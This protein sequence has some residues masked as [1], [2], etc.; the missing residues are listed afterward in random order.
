MA[1]SVT[2]KKPQDELQGEVR[3]DVLGGV[4]EEKDS[5]FQF[6]SGQDLVDRIPD[7][8]SPEWSDYVMRQFADGELV[9]GCPNVAGLRRVTRKL[10]GPI[11][12][13]RGFTIQAP[14]LTDQGWQPAVCDYE[15]VV[16][17]TR[18][19][20]LHG[21]EVVYRDCA[22]TWAGNCQNET[23]SKF[24]PETS[25]TRA[26]ARCFRKLLGLKAIAAEEKIYSAGEQSAISGQQILF[27][28]AN[29][30]NLNINVKSFVNSGKRQYN[31]IEEV[32][33]DAAIAMT[34]QLGKYERKEKQIPNVMIGFQGNW[35]QS[36]TKTY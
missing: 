7:F 33:Y 1:K 32:P 11:I 5:L 13:S 22:E 21:R 6:P 12:S 18:E 10:I 35:R 31:Y 23:V 28:E 30:R 36:F 16:L 19:D 9:D 17:W 2:K 27:I 4:T 15:I 8:N 25:S 20:V 29:C 26:E 14:T 24:R 3:D 34:E